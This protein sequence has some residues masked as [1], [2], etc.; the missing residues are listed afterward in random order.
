MARRLPSWIF[1][2][3]FSLPMSC[4]CAPVPIHYPVS[5]QPPRHFIHPGITSHYTHTPPNT[6]PLHFLSPSPPHTHTHRKLCSVEIWLLN[7]TTAAPST[8][9]LFGCNCT[10][11]SVVHYIGLDI[12]STKWMDTNVLSH[13]HIHAHIYIAGKGVLIDVTKRA[14]V[15]M[16]VRVRACMCK[17]EKETGWTAL[18]VVLNWRACV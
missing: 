18:L 15:F 8:I 14:G 2:S 10:I 4:T 3:L 13:T 9:L 6:Q 16:C 17:G 1:W 7:W 11:L 5:H 12:T